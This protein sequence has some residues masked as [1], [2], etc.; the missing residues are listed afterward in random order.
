[1]RNCLLTGGAGQ[2]RAG[3]GTPTTLGPQLKPLLPLRPPPLSAVDD[4]R[5]EADARIAEVAAATAQK[6]AENAARL[7]LLKEELYSYDDDG[8][9]GGRDGHRSRS[10]YGLGR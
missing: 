9:R 2:G 5:D 6:K 8:Y 3:H 7:A 4:A 10:R 1:M